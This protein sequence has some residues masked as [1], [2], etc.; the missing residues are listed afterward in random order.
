MTHEHPPKQASPKEILLRAH[1]AAVRRA[2]GPATED[3][4]VT[5]SP[6]NSGRHR[7]HSRPC[8]IPE[9]GSRA[10]T[11]AR[12]D[13]LAAGGEDEPTCGGSAWRWRRCPACSLIV[14]Q[15]AANG[16]AGGQP[17]TG[18]TSRDRAP[19]AQAWPAGDDDWRLGAA[20]LS[21]DP[22]LFFPI[23]YT[24]A[25]LQQVAAAKAICAHCPVQ[26]ECLA[27]AQRTEAHGIWGGLTELERLRA[28][29]TARVWL[30]VGSPGGWTDWLA[31][32]QC[33]LRADLTI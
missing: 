12:T 20:C 29:R 32:V 24:G 9:C 33:W 4:S 10:L 8:E 7:K 23:S 30:P 31:A 26:R 17:P 28:S 16:P 21:V 5:A 14:L 25:S 13:T 3:P 6:A 18:V 15:S 1:G 11:G 22:E 2:D 19:G 27:F